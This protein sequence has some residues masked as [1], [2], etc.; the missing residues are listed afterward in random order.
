MNDENGQIPAGLADLTKVL[1]SIGPTH[2][3]VVN[4][5]AAEEVYGCP[6]P[7]D[8]R[9]FVALFGHGS[10]EGVVAV[11]L[12]SVTP[13]EPQWNRVS[14]LEDHALADPSVNNWDAASSG[15]GHRLEDLLLWGETAAADAFAW[16]TVSPDPDRWPVAVYS[17]EAVTW[18]V[19]PCGMA[20]FL[21][22]LL[23][24]DFDEWPIGETSLRDVA[25]PR[26]LHD[27]DEE[28]VWASGTDP[29]E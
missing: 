1:R 22:R 11:R 8:Y 16:I 7:A 21:L 12:P 10:I 17:R 6:F 2:G 5:K 27:Q 26:F 29:W 25:Q 4:W 20:E 14:R 24:D 18:S 9:S 15:A 13:G 28:A 3:D 19:F 23:G